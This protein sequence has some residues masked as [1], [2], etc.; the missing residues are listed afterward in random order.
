MKN[1]YLIIGCALVASLLAVL[2]DAHA[3]GIKGKVTAGEKFT[4]QFVETESSEGSAKV[5]FYWQVENGVLPIMPPVLKMDQRVGI[6]LFRKDGKGDPGFLP[7]HP[8]VVGAELMPAVVVAPPKTT[9]KFHN[10][11]PFVHELYSKDLGKIFAPELQ[12]SQQTRQIQFSNEGVYQIGCQ[13]TPHLEGYVIIVPGVV[14][15][16]NPAEDG[17]FMFEDIDPGEYV[18]KVYFDG[19]AVSKID[20]TVED[21]DK[22]R[23]YASVEVKLTPPSKKKKEKS[24]KKPDKKGGGEKAAAKKEDEKKSSGKSK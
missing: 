22:E 10:T 2:P 12:S 18:V 21:S 23:D 5:D 20:V 3:G 7:V 15:F 8:D 6:A 9:L 4:E 13:M 24:G 14:A 17:S 11:D 16:K 1:P 19:E